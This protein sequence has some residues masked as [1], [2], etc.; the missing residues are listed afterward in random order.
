MLSQKRFLGEPCLSWVKTTAGA[1][2]VMATVHMVQARA[3]GYSLSLLTDAAWPP[4][5][6]GMQSQM[7][8]QVDEKRIGQSFPN[9]KHGTYLARFEACS[10]VPRG[11][12]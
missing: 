4:L 5:H 7:G 11:L 9:R 2:P 1:M 12:K 3:L 8:I 6:V 10:F